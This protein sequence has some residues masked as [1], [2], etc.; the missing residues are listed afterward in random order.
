MS[1]EDV[2]VGLHDAVDGEP[3][4]DF[5]P[6]AL[7]ASARHQVKRRRA[8]VAAG[9]ATMAV[10]AAAVAVPVALGRGETQVA[11]PPASSATSATPT[12]PSAVQPPYY[13]VNDLV[14]RS[15][16]MATHLRDVVPDVLPE[17]SDLSYGEFGG[18]AAGDFHDGQN[19][20][21]APVSFTLDGARYSLFVAV[22]APG[23]PE[24]SRTEVCA[25]SGA[26]CKQYGERDGG[27]LVIT[28]TDLGDQ[29][30]SSMYHFRAS[31]SVV[32][33]AAYNYDMAGKTPPKYAPTIPVT[34]DQLTRLAT[35]PDLGL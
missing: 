23:A 12:S 24:M 29:A 30:I 6:D 13:T 28:T 15:K 22:F 19:Y 34:L 31:G 7:V 20:M 3:P 25:A 2:R 16:E 9:V 14:R 32:Q 18:E 5:D 26:Y 4:L 10:V 11:Q 21:N 27:P 8:L 17:A 33:I 35:D 1:E